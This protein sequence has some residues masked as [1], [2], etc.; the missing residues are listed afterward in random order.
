MRIEKNIIRIFA[1]ILAITAITV[2]TV[3]AERFY[4]LTYP[5]MDDVYRLEL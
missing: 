4:D 2:N 1:L 3:N 5:W